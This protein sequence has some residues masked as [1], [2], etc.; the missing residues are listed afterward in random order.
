METEYKDIVNKYTSTPVYKASQEYTNERTE[1]NLNEL[2]KHLPKPLHKYVLD[3]DKYKWGFTIAI[4]PTDQQYL[5]YHNTMP[6]MKATLSDHIVI[7]KRGDVI[8][9][10]YHYNEENVNIGDIVSI[11]GNHETSLGE[12]TYIYDMALDN[13]SWKSQELPKWAIDEERLAMIL[14]AEDVEYHQCIATNDEQKDNEIIVLPGYKSVVV[15]I[16]MTQNRLDYWTE[17]QWKLKYNKYKDFSYN[18]DIVSPFVR[19]ELIHLLEFKPDSID[20]I[21]CFGSASKIGA[22]VPGKSDLDFILVIKDYY[23]LPRYK[24]E[25]IYD[26]IKR[27]RNEFPSTVF[28]NTNI[29]TDEFINILENPYSRGYIQNVFIEEGVVLYQSDSFQDKVKVVFK[30]W[31]M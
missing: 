10:R 2:L 6:F 8:G 17:R 18:L 31:K 19:E 22:F 9:L 24:V 23:K 13:D 28:H 12:G 26:Y 11:K 3:T 21:V 20:S 16:C 14:Y 7:K 15:D 4:E 1:S 30:Q 27:T 25:E 29:S 5:D